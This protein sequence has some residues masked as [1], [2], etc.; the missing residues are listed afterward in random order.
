M[1]VYVKFDTGYGTKCLA[2][3]LLPST[4]I[5]MPFNR[6]LMGEKLSAKLLVKLLAN[7]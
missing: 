5:E 6:S 2:S 1:G 4:Q 3:E 7:R